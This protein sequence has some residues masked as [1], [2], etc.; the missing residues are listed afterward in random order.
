M[1]SVYSSL[2]K[3]VIYKKFYVLPVVRIMFLSSALRHVI[4]TFR[5]NTL[6]RKIASKHLKRFVISELRIS[7]RYR[8]EDG[9]T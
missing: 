8:V 1:D 3:E 9:F 5:G 2:N 6:H 7:A 4:Q